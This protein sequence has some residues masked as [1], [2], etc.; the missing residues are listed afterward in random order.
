MDLKVGAALVCALLQGQTVLSAQSQHSKRR[1]AAINAEASW[2]H[3][4]QDQDSHEDSQDALLTTQDKYNKLVTDPEGTDP[5]LVKA[6]DIAQ[7]LYESMKKT[8]SPG[9][10]DQKLDGNLAKIHSCRRW[11]DVQKAYK[12]IDN[13]GLVHALIDQV[14]HHDR[15]RIKDDLQKQIPTMKFDEEEWSCV[16]PTSTPGP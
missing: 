3:G 13:V 9:N 4:S 2:S 15:K 1:Q 14:A 7:Q 10:D 8:D 5:E 16:E 6:R 12:D 11:K